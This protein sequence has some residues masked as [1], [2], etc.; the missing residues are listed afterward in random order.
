MILLAVS[1]EGL[2][3]GPIARETSAVT[4]WHPNYRWS[5]NSKPFGGTAF[6]VPPYPVLRMP[7]AMALMLRSRGSS[8]SARLASSVSLR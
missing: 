6:G 1:S 5:A 4:H 8:Q 2:L 3:R 7:A